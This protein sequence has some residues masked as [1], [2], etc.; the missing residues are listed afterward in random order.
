MRIVIVVSV[1]RMFMRDVATVHGYDFVLGI[2]TGFCDLCE[3]WKFVY[4]VFVDSVGLF[5]MRCVF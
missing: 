3:S 5:R 1:G 4:D 2:G